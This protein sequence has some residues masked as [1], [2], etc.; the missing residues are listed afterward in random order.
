MY[1]LAS[2]LTTFLGLGMKKKY[3]F[4]LEYTSSSVYVLLSYL[5]PSLSNPE[6]YF[7]IHLIIIHVAIRAIFFPLL[8]I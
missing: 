7:F 8:F 4:H 2:L 6:P 3:A 1:G 5:V